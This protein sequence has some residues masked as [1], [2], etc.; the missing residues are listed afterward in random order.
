MS[1]VGVI[2]GSGLGAFADSLED[3]RETAYAALP[4]WPVSRVAGHAGKLVEGRIGSSEVIVLSGR[5]HLYEGY[6]PQQVAHG[7][8]E[9]AR[10]GVRSLI[11]TNAAGAINLSYKPGDLV[12]ISDHINLQGANPLTGASEEPRFP[13][14]SEAYP[15]EFRAIARAGRNLAEGVY[16]GV[17]GPSFETPAE[18]RYLRAIG[19][20]LVGMS[21]IMEAIAANHAGMKVLGISCVTNMAA[22][23]LPRKLTHAEVLETGARAASALTALLRDVVTACKW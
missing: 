21:T 3:R 17:P 4:G 18:I 15:A 7:V 22:G 1:K 11:L 13:D 8:R 16:A 6:T 5:V 14:M 2:L 20:D 10:R 23:V 12:L 19:A 9:L